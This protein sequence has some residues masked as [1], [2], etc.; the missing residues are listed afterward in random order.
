MNIQILADDQLRA[1]ERLRTNLE[2]LNVFML[3]PDGVGI[4]STDAGFVRYLFSRVRSDFQKLSET[5]SVKGGL[6]GN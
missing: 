2:K 4:S 3:S 5:L 6:D 1:I